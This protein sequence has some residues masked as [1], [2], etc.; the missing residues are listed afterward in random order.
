MEPVIT[1]VQ[2]VFISCGCNRTPHAADWGNNGLICYGACNAV[3]IYDPKDHGGKV[4]ATYTGHQDRVNA[5]KWVKKIDN[6][7]EDEF[8]SVSTDQ[9]GLVWTKKQ[10]RFVVTS[11]L[12]GHQG[13]VNVVDAVYCRLSA[14]KRKIVESLVI[15]TAAVD[16]TIRIWER[17]QGDAVECKKALLLTSGLCMAASLTV[18]PGGF[19]ILAAGLDDSNIHVY[20][21]S[22]PPN[23]ALNLTGAEQISSDEPVTKPSAS[24]DTTAPQVDRI[25]KQLTLRG[26]EDWVTALQFTREDSG[27]LLLASGSLDATVR[28]WRFHHTTGDEAKKELTVEQ[29]Q[30]AVGHRRLDVGLESVLL[31]H[32]GRVYGLCW[33]P[34]ILTDSGKSWTQPLQLL[35]ASLDKTVVVWAPEDGGGGVWLEQD[36]MGEVGGNTLGFYGTRFGP[37][38]NTILAHSY[39]GGFHIWHRAQVLVSIEEKEED[40]RTFCVS[41]DESEE[42]LLEQTRGPNLDE[43]ST[44]IV[45]PS[46]FGNKTHWR[47]VARIWSPGVAVGGHF[48]Q[49]ND[50]A[51]EPKFGRYIMTVSSDQTA[52]LY[53]PWV[54]GFS[55]RKTAT[56]ETVLKQD[57]SWHEM[58]R[59]QIH[60]YDISCIAILPHFSFVSGADEKVIRAFNV[61]RIFVDN[62]LR[63]CAP[64]SSKAKE[65][66]GKTPEEMGKLVSMRASVPPLG[67]SNKEWKQA[68][69]DKIKDAKKRCIGKSTLEVIQIW[70]EVNPN[71][72]PPQLDAPPPEDMLLQDFLWSETMKLYGHGYD[73]FSL[74]ASADGKVIASACKATNEEHAAILC[75]DTSTWRKV[76]RL[77]SHKLTVT[78]LQFS[79]DDKYLLSVS[80]DRTWSVFQKSDSGPKLVGRSDKNT[81]VHTRIIWCCG[82]SHDSA[83]FATGSRDGK[84]VVWGLGEE[85]HPTLGPFTPSSDH[86]DLPE[87]SITSLSFAPGFVLSPL[88]YLLA[89]GTETGEIRLYGWKASVPSPWRFL[90]QLSGDHSHHLSIKKLAFRPENVNTED[91]QESIDLHL[92]SCGLDHTVKVHKIVVKL[93]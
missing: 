84:I 59:P 27:D 56:L 1:S 68:E 53:A 8:L 38:G 65:F 47:R 54:R 14:G 72:C 85:N 7:P 22:Q 30:I 24:D 90:F 49:V 16:S 51:W 34:P 9:C 81:G 79:P 29:Q 88:E 61:T 70:S 66:E 23:P 78:Q 6:S 91:N 57:Y 10:D 42:L 48:D 92:A 45:I 80:R 82:W 4:L 39:T 69:I 83:Y 17:N 63:L 60:G 62:F 93:K 37:R 73:I 52:R 2:P 19:I 75:W 35:T 67:L 12:K 46:I 25:V 26:H 5:V 86:L 11:V 28:L 13:P 64:Y 41:E 40:K 36:R 77:V 58:A 44:F 87:E 55:N 21:F 31:G 89:A 71:V 43:Y 33:H 3:A 32:D 50:L 18:S 76:G 15:V 74:A 20:T